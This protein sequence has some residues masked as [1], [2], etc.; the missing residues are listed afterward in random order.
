[1]A[2]LNPY[3]QVTDVRDQ[4]GDAD[5]K[6]DATLIERAI[7]ATSRAI[8]RYCGGRRFWQDPVPVTR[9][10]TA[11]CPGVLDVADVS[12]LEGL[13]VEIDPAAS[14]SWTTLNTADYHLE[15]LDADADG[16][17]HAWWTIVVDAGPC[18]PASTRPLVRVTAK[19]GWSAIPDDVTAAAVLKAV[20][21]FKRKDAPFGVA[22]FGDFGVVRIGRYDPD[23]TALLQPFVRGAVA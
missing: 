3:C 4:L 16:D 23:V 13:L 14:G 21:L 19:W 6:L 20:S 1:M 11:A 7:N 22:G 9:R 8:E 10:F 17:A 18:L 12:T 2:L 15:P 5:A